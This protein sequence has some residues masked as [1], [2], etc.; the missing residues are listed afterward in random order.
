M[1]F[2]TP[3]FRCCFSLRFR[4]KLGSYCSS[5][6]YYWYIKILT[7]LKELIFAGNN[8]RFFRGF[9]AKSRKFEPAKIFPSS[10]PR[11]LIPAKNAFKIQKLKWIQQFD[12]FLD[13]FH[14]GHH[15]FHLAF[16]FTVLKENWVKLKQKHLSRHFKIWSNRKK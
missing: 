7:T 2:H 9:S 10:K 13:K 12:T 5:I 1:V 8:F 15:L 6:L 4:L 16:N 14:L 3:T 11:K